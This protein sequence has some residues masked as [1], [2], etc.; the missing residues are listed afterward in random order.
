MIGHIQADFKYI[1]LFRILSKQL[2]RFIIKG[3]L[4]IHS[5]YIIIVKEGLLSKHGY[6]EIVFQFL[7]EIVRLNYIKQ[8]K[9]LMLV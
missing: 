6:E 9:R 4:D 7:L 1:K 2:E 5:F 3:R 8:V